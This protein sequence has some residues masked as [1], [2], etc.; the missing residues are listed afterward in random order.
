MEQEESEGKSG[1]NLVAKSR[2]KLLAK[3]KK[4]KSLTVEAS[5]IEY[6]RIH[7]LISGAT[8]CKQQTKC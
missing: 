5:A 2:W 6:N 8:G 7:L 4:M 1:S 3:V